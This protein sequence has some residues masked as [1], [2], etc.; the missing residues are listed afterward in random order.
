VRFVPED[1]QIAG[2]IL[3][4][5]GGLVIVIYAAAEI[6]IGTF[7]TSVSSLNGFPVTDIGGLLLAGWFGVFVGLAI[8]VLSVVV[9]GTPV[10][11]GRVGAL[12]IFFAFLSLVSVGGGNGI[13]FLLSV[14]G[15]TCSIVFGPDRPAPQKA[16]DDVSEAHPAPSTEERPT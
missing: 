14:L 7:V 2:P 8:V 4:A 10:E 15:G 1:K 6:Y 11:H 12:I 3:A 16:S 9:V 5:V 13:G